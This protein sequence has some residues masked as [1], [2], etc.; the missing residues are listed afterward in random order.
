MIKSLNWRLT[1]PSVYSI[2]N[3]LIAQWD[4]FLHFHFGHISYNNQNYYL[5]NTDPGNQGLYEEHYVSFKLANHVS[6]R[7]FR[8]TI[9]VL[10]ASMLDISILKYS[11]RHVAAALLF[12]AIS[13]YFRQT[14]YALLTF[15]SP[16]VEVQDFQVKEMQGIVEEMMVSFVTAAIGIDSFDEICPAASALFPFFNVELNNDLPP[17]CKIQPKQR[18]E[19][20]YEEFL[21]YQTH[22]PTA[23]IFVK[24]HIRQAHAR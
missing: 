11:P 20:H 23:L 19:A 3:W 10:D 16:Y 2:V 15:T 17:V 12:L 5:Q 18:L 4:S 24:N 7:R 14:H 8:E 9:Q 22:N 21:A 13:E 1:G 6:Y